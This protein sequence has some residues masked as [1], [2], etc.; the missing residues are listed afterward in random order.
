MVSPWV[1]ETTEKSYINFMYKRP[2]K[3]KIKA[4]ER[5][6]K[7]SSGSTFRKEITI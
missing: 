1:K 5:E 3:I 4:P 7:L 6:P 2:C